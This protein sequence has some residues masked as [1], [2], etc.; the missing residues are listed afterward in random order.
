MKTFS[1]L[2]DRCAQRRITLKLIREYRVPFFNCAP[3]LRIL[4]IA[5]PDIEL[6]EHPLANQGRWYWLLKSDLRAS[7]S[8]A[9]GPI[10]WYGSANHC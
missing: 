1:A 2:S 7:L 8:A 10:L 5:I 3:L 9:N 4:F 6:N